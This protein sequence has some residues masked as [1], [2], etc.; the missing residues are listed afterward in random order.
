MEQPHPL[1]P[2]KYRNDWLI[3][4]EQYVK[5]YDELSPELKKQLKSESMAVFKGCFPIKTEH[6]VNNFI[7]FA[8]T[9]GTFYEHGIVIGLGESPNK[10]MTVQMAIE[11]K[12][13]GYL[14]HAYHELPIS[15]VSQRFVLPDRTVDDRPEE[16][17][18]AGVLNYVNLPK[19]V[20]RCFKKTD[21]TGTARM[22]GQKFYYMIQ[23]DPR[24]PYEY[25]TH[26]NCYPCQLPTKTFNYAIEQKTL[27]SL[28]ATHHINLLDLFD[29]NMDIKQHIPE[30]NEQLKSIDLSLQY[31]THIDQLNQKINIIDHTESG[32][33]LLSFVLILK[34][35][36]DYL[37]MDVAPIIRP[38]KFVV[39]TSTKFLKLVEQAL[40][41][42]GHICAQYSGQPPNKH[43]QII[44]Y[45]NTRL[46]DDNISTILNSE[47]YPQCGR[48]IRSNTP[49][50][51]VNKLQLA[52]GD[53]QHTTQCNLFR[54][55]MFN[56]ILEK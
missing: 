54:I 46:I 32:G 6:Q 24:G 55:H 42:I 7:E 17:L 1:L 12:E 25:I 26:K 8:R 20:I 49:K 10:I 21:H 39:F 30:F 19:D 48:C 50:S 35:L 9:I 11:F 38:L 16:G 31:L 15:S 29:L 33:S 36:A 3:T 56:Y 45:D 41:L 51:W 28:V 23:V 44:S 14:I 18:Y 5:Y 37:H 52:H 27:F 4:L 47:E 22:L 43:Y 40:M 2:I 53:E 34:Q 13:H